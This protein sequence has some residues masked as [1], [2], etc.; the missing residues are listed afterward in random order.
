MQ[1][2]NL[3]YYFFFLM[4]RRPPRSTL[5]P[6]TTLFRSGGL[7]GA[8]AASSFLVAAIEEDL[9]PVIRLRPKAHP[10]DVDQVGLHDVRRRSQVAAIDELRRN[11]Q[12]CYSTRPSDARATPS[13]HQCRNERRWED[14]TLRWE[15]GA[16]EQRRG[17][18]S[19]SPPP[20]RSRCDSRRC[21]NGPDGRPEA[22]RESGVRERSESPAGRPR[23]PRQDAGE[24]A[25]PRRYGSD[26]DRDVRGFGSS[27]P[28]GGGLA[29]WKG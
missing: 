13:D 22:H 29:L 16:L 10:L 23:Y 3:K 18:A 24:S 14:R 19:G 21:R 26:L 5:F 6:Y 17:H 25:R 8:R 1:S 28:S 11:P 12:T 15:G 9:V 20:D 4:I 2:S 27:L 7:H